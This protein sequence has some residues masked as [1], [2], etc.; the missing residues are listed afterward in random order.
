MIIINV[1]MFN[2]LGELPMIKLKLSHTHTHR[3]IITPASATHHAAAQTDW[4][5]YAGPRSR[6]SI[7]SCSRLWLNNCWV[8]TPYKG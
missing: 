2:R 6:N 8:I 4:T 3:H 7:F 1:A 5:V